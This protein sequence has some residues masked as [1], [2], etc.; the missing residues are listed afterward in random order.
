MAMAESKVNVQKR[1]AKGPIKRHKPL[2]I[3]KSLSK[4]WDLYLLL[5]PV[6]AYFIIFKYIPM[7]GVQIAFRNYRPGSGYLGSEWVGLDHFLRYFN[8]YNFIPTLRNTLVLSFYLLFASFPA[9]IF[10]ALILNEMRNKYFKKTLQ[11]VTYAP[12]FLSMVV[13]I[14]MVQSFLSPETGI[15]NNLLAAVGL[16]RVDYLSEPKWF[17]HIFVLSDIWKGT[18]W[19]SIIYMATLSNIDPQLYEAAT[20]DGAGKFKRLIYITLPCLAPVIVLMLILESGK[21]MSVGFEKVFLLQNDLNIEVSEVISTYVYKVGIR[22][23]QFSYSTAI[24][25]FNSVVNLIMLVTV[26]KISSKFSDSSLW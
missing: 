6:V 18:G 16:D 1:S 17:R 2:T 25:L 15:I 14:G 12:H 5:I 13:M 3:K 26:N 11:T 19:S 9:P 22:S 20:I 24:D 10:L 7:Y 21:I 8:S 23:M 4:Y